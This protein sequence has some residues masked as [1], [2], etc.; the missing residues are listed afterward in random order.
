MCWFHLQVNPI[1]FVPTGL[2]LCQTQ[3][4][5]CGIYQSQ[6]VAPNWLLQMICSLMPRAAA[7]WGADW[8]GLLLGLWLR[9]TDEVEGLESWEQGGFELW[10]WLA[11][12]GG[13]V[14]VCVCQSIFGK[15]LWWKLFSQWWWIQVRCIYYILYNIIV[16]YF[17]SSWCSTRML[18]WCYLNSVTV[19]IWYGFLVCQG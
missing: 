7:G 4:L 12:C 19:T 1:V 5:H 17:S 9:A 18:R 16:N 8:P 14:C 11:L 6:V 15:Q 2:H 13:R 3:L 10:T